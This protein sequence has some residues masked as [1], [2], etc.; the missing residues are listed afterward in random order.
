MML[1]R[2]LPAVLLLASLL[3]RSAMAQQKFDLSPEQPNR[4]RSQPVPE[5]VALI[6]PGY[7]FAEP[8]TLTVA[9]ALGLLP[10]GGIADDSKTYIGTEPDIAQLVADSLGL[11][12]KLVHVAWADWPLGLASGKYDAV[13]SNVTVTEARKEKFDFS[14][15]RKDT[16][17]IYV[18]TSS[19]ITVIKEPKDIAGLR[20]IVSASTNQEQILLRWDAQN[21]AAGL[22]PIEIQYY[23]DDVLLN[24]ALEAGRADAYFGPNATSAYKAAVT[25]KTRLVGTFSGGWPLTAEIAVTTRKG[26]GLA[27]PITRAINTQ[28]ANGN[29]A[30]VLSRWNVGAEAIETSRTNPPGLPKS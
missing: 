27:E 19:P 11:K 25:G 15:Y 4:P 10:L 1:R 29:Y 22:K 16:L 6:P 24:L 5:A 21:R 26:S 14:T 13:I 3:P 18:T 9:H 7:P 17:G 20:V 8:G 23:D 30:R 2:N 12:L 28:I